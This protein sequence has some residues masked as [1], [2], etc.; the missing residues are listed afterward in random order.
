MWL[1]VEKDHQ[2]GEVKSLKEVQKAFFKGAD[3]E[4]LIRCEGTGK[5]LIGGIKFV[6]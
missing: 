1:W 3:Y 6:F 5:N 2:K 4:F